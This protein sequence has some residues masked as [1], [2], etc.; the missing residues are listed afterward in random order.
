MVGKATA[1]ATR[2]VALHTLLDAI[3]QGRWRKQIERIRATYN[4]GSTNPRKAIDP[5]KKKLPGFTVS[6]RFAHRDKEHLIEHSGYICADLD[7]LGDRISRVQSDLRKSPH[8]SFMF[9]SPSGDGL[10]AG[11]K[12][13]A[14]AAR[15]GDSF[16]AI[17]KHVLTLTG[18]RVDA[19][20]KDPARLCFVSY[21]PNTEV[22]ERA[23]AIEPLPPEKK[24]K[25][26]DSGAINLSERQHIAADLLGNIDWQSETRGYIDCPGINLHTTGDGERDCEIHLDGA[27]TVYC[28]HDSC[29]SILDGINHELRSRVGKA[30]P[31]KAESADDATIARLAALPVLEYERVREAEAEKLGCRQSVLD[32]LVE[33]RRPKQSSDGLQGTVVKLPDV[34]P[35]AEPVDGAEV[36]DAISERFSRRIVLPEGA[37]DTLALYSGATH[38]YELFPCFPR[39][40]IK[41]PEPECGKTTLR[42]QVALFVPRPLPTE[43]LSTAVLFRL[44]AAQKPTILADEVDAWMKDNEELR[45]LLNAGHRKGAMALRC[46][47]DNNEVR[48]F[49][50][51][52]PAVLCGIGNLPTTLHDRSIVI[53]LERAKGGEIK[54]RFDSRHV[55]AEQKLRCQ[56]AR[57]CVDNRDAIQACDPQLPDGV[58]NRLADNWRPLFAIAEVAG[59]KWPKKCADAFAKLT[60]N[61]PDAESLRVELLSDIRRV[62]TAER[63][64]SKDLIDALARMKE[65]PWSEVCRGK[66]I[67]E[68]WLARTLGAFGIKSKSKSMRIDDDNAKGYEKADFENAFARYLPEPRLSS[69]T[70]SQHEGKPPKSI[71]HRNK[72]V[73]DEKSV[74]YIGKCDGVT[75]KKAGNAIRASK[76]PL[77]REAAERFEGKIV[78]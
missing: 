2:D 10:K 4:N 73:T 13:S 27:P 44:V 41:S 71:R 17:E 15:H 38:C 66:P 9:R 77:I 46:E 48:G 64:F 14:D 39:L 35:W 12:T 53:G 21:D 26:T 43:N 69:V 59:G 32:Q 62:F 19:S 54:E 49:A 20:G 28:F 6:G 34:E 1:T 72:F 65:R 57:F 11:F 60:R 45:G 50:A 7:K 42:D 18:V 51:Y 23:S 56:L 31:V 37:A 8:L 55:E 68:R 16:R 61:E 58:F 36:L 29:R 75:D 47:G 76:H 30:E 22:F 63:M 33:A 78:T 5:L 3:K 25:R 67:N 52:A 70:A 24:P 74:P 40:N